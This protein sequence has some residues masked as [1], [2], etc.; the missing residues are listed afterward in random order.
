MALRG[1][2]PFRRT[3]ALPIEAAHGIRALRSF[4]ELI[5]VNFAWVAIAYRFIVGWMLSED[6]VLMPRLLRRCNE[7]VRSPRSITTDLPNQRGRREAH[8]MSGSVS[9]TGGNDHGSKNQ[10]RAA[11]QA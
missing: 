11:S 6:R 1:S 8:A 5:H 3:A 2:E 10:A 7:I 4:R 9:A